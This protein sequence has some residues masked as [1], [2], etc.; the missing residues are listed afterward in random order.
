M[1][2]YE[3]FALKFGRIFDRKR[4]ENG[5]KNL[6]KEIERAKGFVNFED[7]TYLFNYSLGNFELEKWNS[8]EDGKIVFIGR[9]I[10]KFRDKISEIFEI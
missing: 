1:H 5:V 8:K 3:S 4:F 2:G 6:P 10:S 7:G 9:G